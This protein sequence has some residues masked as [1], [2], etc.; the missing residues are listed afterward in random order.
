MKREFIINIILLFIINIL[1]KP[2]YIFGV[3]ARIQD[4]VGTEAYGLYFFYFN[5]IFL[6]Q[7]INDPGLQNWNAQYI[8]KNRVNIQSHFSN[9]LQIKFILAFIFISIVCLSAFFLGYLDTWMIFFMAVNFVLSSLFM[10]FR[11]VVAGLGHYR[12]DSLLSSLDKLLMLFILGYLVWFSDYRDNFDIRFLI[13]G[14]TM[15]YLIA[16]LVAFSLIIR[17]ISLIFKPIRIEDIKTVI[18][19]SA[20]YVLIMIFMTTYNK[21]DGVMLGWLLDD[22]NYQAGVYAAAYR[23]YDAANMVGYLFAALLL[24]MYA[25]EIND[26]NILKELLDT[27]IKYTTSLSLVMLA[28]IWFFGDDI[29]KLL[30]SEYQPDFF[31]SLRFLMISYFMVATA[32]IYGTLLVATGN[33]KNLNI[34]F[35]AGLVVNIVL[36]LILIPSFK[37]V[38]ASIATLLTQI[39]VMA[40][41]IYLVKKQMNIVI[42]ASELRRIVSFALSIIGA[43]FILTAVLKIEWYL[44]LG[45]CILICVLLSFIFKII[46]QK[47]LALIRN[48]K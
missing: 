16:C 37:A 6:F 44:I 26:K 1:I 9:L 29:L 17:K 19:S 4:T 24:P 45:L 33:V 11:G 35:A 28:S 8:P 25:S 14:Q 7:F 21:L 15:A 13:Y 22:N 12:S 39:L 5:F 32:Y 42:S 46:N 38:G 48:R 18:Q 10:V 36:C 41:Q 30:Y 31:K 40:G 34:V 3:E 20:P 27:G 47:D 23:F 2:I 43:F